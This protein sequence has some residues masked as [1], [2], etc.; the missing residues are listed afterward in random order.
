MRRTIVYMAVLAACRA[1]ADRCTYCLRFGHVAASCPTAAA[2][3]AG[4]H[5]RG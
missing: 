5:K 1:S 4:P 2:E 3:R